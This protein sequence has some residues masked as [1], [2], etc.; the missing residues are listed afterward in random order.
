M[1]RRIFR[2]DGKDYYFDD[3]DRTWY[4][5][6]RQKSTKFIGCF[7]CAEYNLLTAATGLIKSGFNEHTFSPRLIVGMN[8]FAIG[9]ISDLLDYGAGKFKIKDNR[10][11][12]CLFSVTGK[13]EEVYL[14]IEL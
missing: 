1:R 14:E 5:G 7:D 13:I 4:S 11:D 2:A 3:L 10:K 6:N 8:A 12:N 9:D